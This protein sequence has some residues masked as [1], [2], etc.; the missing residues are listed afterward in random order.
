MGLDRPIKLNLIFA[1]A[2][3]SI[4][5][6]R[7]LW[8]ISAILLKRPS[9]SSGWVRV[10]FKQTSWH[11]RNQTEHPLSWH[12]SIVL[13]QT[14]RCIRQLVKHFPEIAL[15]HIN[16]FNNTV[17]HL[18]QVLGIIFHLSHLPV[19]QPVLC[20]QMC[21]EQVNHAETF[22]DI[23]SMDTSWMLFQSR[24]CIICHISITKQL[25]QLMSSCMSKV[26]V[27]SLNVLSQLQ[28]HIISRS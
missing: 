24:N 16:I 15:R 3:V 4:A 21:L 12:V 11:A 2:S 9:V 10:L 27:H 25:L 28:W 20:P 23:V 26:S 17:S 18:S 22:N 1:F 6:I 19:R 13:H 5:A 14:V 7:H 8:R